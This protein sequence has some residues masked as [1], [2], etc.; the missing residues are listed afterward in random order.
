MPP[1]PK[2]SIEGMNLMDIKNTFHTILLSHEDC[3][4]FTLQE[5]AQYEE[6]ENRTPFAFKKE[7][8]HKQ[9]FD[10]KDEKL[11]TILKVSEIMKIRKDGKLII[12]KIK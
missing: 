2:F 3:R 4:G 5:V 8:Q 1:A 7:H 12:N 11:A 9:E 6:Y 10:K